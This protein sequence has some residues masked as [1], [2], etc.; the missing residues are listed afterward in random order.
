[1]LFPEPGSHL[2]L[3]MGSCVNTTM[4]H[5]KINRYVCG[6][7]FNTTI[8]LYYIITEIIQFQFQNFSRRP[9]LVM[10][11]ESKYNTEKSATCSLAHHKM[12]I[13]IVLFCFNTP[14]FDHAVDPLVHEN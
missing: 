1:M 14:T 7:R 12:D 5:T 6:N 8:L 10:A 4:Q 2:S 3:S 11:F 9:E 13:I